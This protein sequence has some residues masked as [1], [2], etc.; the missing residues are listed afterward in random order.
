MFSIT[1]NKSLPLPPQP[2]LTRW[3]TWIEE[4]IFYAEYFDQIKDVVLSFYSSSAVCIERVQD[5]FKQEHVK[6]DL[7]YIKINFK[8]IFDSITKLKQTIYS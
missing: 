2:T 6:N 8:I 4:A 1:N 5:Y 7:I 3:V